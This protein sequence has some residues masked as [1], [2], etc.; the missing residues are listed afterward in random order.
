MS[1]EISGITGFNL[2]E[3]VEV[4]TIVVVIIAAVS[5]AV[6]A[7]KTRKQTKIDSAHLSLELIKR[8]REKDF[9][10]IVDNIFD[11]KSSEC[12]DVV[13]ERFINHLD[14]IAKFNEEKIINIDHISQIYGG[15]LR[16]IKT[17][18]HIQL[19]IKKDEKLF[20]PLIKLYNKI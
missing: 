1:L 2:V 8:V 7:F 14:M 9:A 3:S 13:L 6:T 10:E 16:K 15:L 5:L 17:D 20:I 18:S 12:N 19:I 4:A 11:D